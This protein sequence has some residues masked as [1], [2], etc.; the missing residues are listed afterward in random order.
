[1]PMMRAIIPKNLFDPAKIAAAVEAGLDEGAEGVSQDF[2]KTTR[3]WNGGVTFTTTKKPWQRTVSTN[4]Q[5]YGYVNFGTPAH[6]IVPRRGKF[7]VFF[8]GGKPK[9]TPKVIGSSAGSKGT[10]KVFARRVRHPG[11][12]AREFDTTIADKWNSGP[13]AELMQQQINKAAGV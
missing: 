1:M 11:T 6:T 3:G 8:V 13:F 5:R 7:L 12:K 2:D 4:D 9:T 10:K